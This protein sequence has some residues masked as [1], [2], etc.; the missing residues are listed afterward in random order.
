MTRLLHRCLRV[1]F[2]CYG[3]CTTSHNGKH[4]LVLYIIYSRL[5]TYSSILSV[6]FVEDFLDFCAPILL[7]PVALCTYALVAC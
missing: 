7:P 4:I 6:R 1:G 2:V 3:S 5:Y